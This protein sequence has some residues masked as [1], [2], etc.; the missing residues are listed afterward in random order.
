MKLDRDRCATAL[1]AA[2]ER[3][4]AELSSEGYL[5]HLSSSALSTAVA[6][7]ALSLAGKTEQARHGA[8]WLTA[9]INEDGGWGDT[10]DS[11]SNLATTLLAWGAVSSIDG[12]GTTS[13]AETW[14][15]RHIGGLEAEQIAR[16]VLEFYGEDRTFAAPILT[17][18]AL[19]KRLGDSPDSW[20]HV[21]QLPFELAVMPHQFFKWL[22]LPVVSYALPALIAI[23]LVRHRHLPSSGSLRAFRNACTGRV[24][25]K[26]R[27]MQPA[28]GGF[29][30]AAPLT[31]FVGMSLIGAGCGQH[32]AAQACIDF[33]A[34][35]QRD[36][37][38]WPI[39]TNLA[40][41]LTSLAVRAL[42]QTK[43]PVGLSSEQQGLIRR[44]LLDSQHTE[45]HP[46]TIAR[47]GG[48]A[49][50]HL[51]GGVP[52]ADDT[53]AALI[54]LRRL[55]NGD[56]A[57]GRA[58]ENGLEWLLDLQNADGG[59]P[60]FC[61]GW[62]RLPFDRSCADIT[63]HALRA[64]IEWREDLSAGLRRRL[65]RAVCRGIGF[66]SRSQHSDGSWVPL[67]FGNQF[68]DGHRNPTYGTARVL[69]ALCIL[70]KRGFG[71]VGSML[72][73]G[74]TWLLAAQNNDGGW[75]AGPGTPSSIEETALAV[76]ALA[77]TP[78]TPAVIRGATWLM[79]ATEGGTTFPA[80][81]IGLYF[82]SLWYWEKLY[83]LIFTVDAL[84]T[85]LT[86]RD[87]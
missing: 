37:G 84:G 1:K 72:E 3:L 22:R 50:T 53:S 28:S 8:Q 20:A 34:S 32:P 81:P 30:E 27:K 49:W 38:S 71:R 73:K 31:G 54:A 86:D 85:L 59:W 56:K 67:W 51:S 17:M 36:D 60:T 9:H 68:A 18:C 70:H 12:A 23:G 83:P 63:A 74:R 5:G 7:F 61:R 55:G 46:F 52:D 42:T 10:S 87:D 41:W 80:S 40:T 75:G 58:A 29:L 24:L 77:E 76:R 15:R 6:S 62:G 78:D 47:P 45:T 16:A 19:A 25:G 13:R 65:D 66:L 39:D 82:A 64:C 35:H 33:L 21:P 44:Y 11:P 48:W 4:L 2:R 57:L 43:H 26:L 14:L 79:D 69:E